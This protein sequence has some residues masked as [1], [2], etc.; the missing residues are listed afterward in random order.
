MAKLFAARVGIVSQAAT[1]D[2]AS[3]SLRMIGGFKTVSEDLALCARPNVSN[4]L[5]SS[6]PDK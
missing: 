1:G 3:S 4:G 2:A 5:S 6:W